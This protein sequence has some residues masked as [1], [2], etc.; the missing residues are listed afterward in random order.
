M[1]VAE[2]WMQGHLEVSDMKAVLNLWLDNRDTLAGLSTSISSIFSLYTSW[3][4][5][6]L[7]RQSLSTA[8]LNAETYNVSNEFMQVSAF[9]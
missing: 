8:K 4:I 2:A 7:F 5:G 3:A 6:A 9:L 1:L